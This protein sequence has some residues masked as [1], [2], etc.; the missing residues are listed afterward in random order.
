MECAFYILIFTLAIILAGIVSLIDKYYCIP[1]YGRPMLR[2]EQDKK[3]YPP[4]QQQGNSEEDD[5]DWV[6]K[7][8]LLDALDDDDHQ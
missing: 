8:I 7:I 1:K 3:A 2:P 6:Y 4:N 5:M